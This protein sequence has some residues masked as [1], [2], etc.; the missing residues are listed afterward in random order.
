MLQDVGMCLL[1]FTLCF[2]DDLA[3]VDAVI[4]R[5]RAALDYNFQ[6]FLVNAKSLCL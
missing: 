4:A 5:V 1:E 6:I 2:V 3:T